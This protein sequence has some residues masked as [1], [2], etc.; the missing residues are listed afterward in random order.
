MRACRVEGHFSLYTFF[1]SL[2]TVYFMF[3]IFLDHVNVL[4]VLRRE[5]LVLMTILWA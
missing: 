2:N 5:V 4:P 1:L 3:L